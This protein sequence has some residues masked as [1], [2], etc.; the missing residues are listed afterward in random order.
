MLCR[1][2]EYPL[3]IVREVCVLMPISG[4]GS[5]ETR[6]SPIECAAGRLQGAIGYNGSHLIN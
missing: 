5:L 1:A 4:A 3:S 2:G 6:N